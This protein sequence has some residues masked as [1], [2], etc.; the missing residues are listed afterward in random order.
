V[1]AA[2]RCGADAVK[3]QMFRAAELASAEAPTAAY[4]RERSGATSQREMLAKLELSD[5]ESAQIASRCEE[6]GILLAITP[7]GIED[8]SRIEALN[9]KGHCSQSIGTLALT[10]A[11]S[12]GER[13]KGSRSSDTPQVAAIK[14]ASTDLPNGPLI[15]AAARTGLPMILSTGASTL[16]EIR[17]AVD[18]VARA[19]TGEQLVLL[20]CVSCYPTPIE[21]INLRAVQTLREEFGV[22]VGL[23]DHTTSQ[24]IGAWAVA[25]GACVLEKHFTLDKRAAGPDHAMSLTPSE[26]AEYIHTVREAEKALGTGAVGVSALEEDVRRAARKSIVAARQI[27][28]GT[29]ITAEMLALKRP[30]TGIEPGRMADLI[31]RRASEDIPSDALL[32]WKMVK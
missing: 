7:F 13:G 8:V 2:K 5:G 12:R 9:G 29:R 10:P 11:L 1:D 26:L 16:D 15:D 21:A 18:R 19:G 23:S 31:G 24:H 30:G 6:V 25:A 32:S 28:E 20:H 4:Q 22:P 17:A 14:I 27:T 3:F